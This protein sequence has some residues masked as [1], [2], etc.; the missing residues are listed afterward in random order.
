MIY[1]SIY[2]ESLSEYIKHEL[3]ETEQGIF[4]ALFGGYGIEKKLQTD[5][6][7]L[8]R[9]GDSKYTMIVQKYVDDTWCVKFY[10]NK[11]YEKVV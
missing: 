1:R 5:W 7:Q 8:I 4:N 9:V 10:K 6:F 11:C 2:K 3:T